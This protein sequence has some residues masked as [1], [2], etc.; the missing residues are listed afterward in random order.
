MTVIRETLDKLQWWRLRPDAMLT[1]GNQVD[2]SF[3][4]YIPS[5]RA[6]DAS[7]ALAY[8]PNN[9]SA[10]FD[11]SGFDRPMKCVWIDPRTGQRLAPVDVPNQPDV[12][13]E[14]PGEGD[15]LILIERR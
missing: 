5:A 7:F 9:R 6:D 4:N 15:W 10:V 3:S 11:L 2:E 14:T 1:S 12:R 8:L 13:L